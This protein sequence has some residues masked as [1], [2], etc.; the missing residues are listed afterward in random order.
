MRTLRA[1]MQMPKCLIEYEEYNIGVTPRADHRI[2][3]YVI[4]KRRFFSRHT[5]ITVVNSGQVEIQGYHSAHAQIDPK[6]I[7]NFD[8][9]RDISK[10][11]AAV[12]TSLN[13]VHQALNDQDVIN[14]IKDVAAD[15]GRTGRVR[16]VRHVGRSIEIPD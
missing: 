16:D 12:Q 7:R 13:T 8:D 5:R 1:P 10:V 3:I 11:I 9:F 4:H 15:A 2:E 14:F 6:S